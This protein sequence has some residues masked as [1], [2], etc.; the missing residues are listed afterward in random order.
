MS[1]N[2]KTLYSK[3]FD[4]L[5]KTRSIESAMQLCEWDQ[6]TYMPKE[7]IFF[8]SLTL[9][10][11]SEI[12]HKLKTSPAYKK[13]LGSLIDLKTGEIIHSDLSAKDIQN[14]KVLK[15]DFDKQSKLP[16]KFVK[17]FT[18]LSSESSFM[19]QK[20]KEHSDF[21]SFAPYLKNIVKSNQKK[22]AFLGFKHHPY[23]ALID[24]YE[25]GMTT[26]VLDHLFI[27]LKFELIELLRKIKIKNKK[28][29][30]IET[31]SSFHHQM[32]LGRNLLEAIGLKPEFSRL[33]TTTHPF[34]S[35]IG[36]FDIR[37]TTRVIDDD[38]ISNIYSCLH[39]GGHGLYGKGVS[40]FSLGLPEGQSA[41]LGLDE[42]Q[43]RLY[44]T[45]LGKSYGFIEAML[46]FIKEHLKM[47]NLSL[48]TL[49]ENIN[50]VEPHF[51][52]IESDEISYCLHIILRYEIEKALIEG[53]LKVEDVPKIWN[54][55][56]EEYLGIIP[57]HDSQGCLQ[58]IHWSMGAIGYFPTYAL[59]NIY[60]ASLF[61]VFK[62]SHPQFDEELKRFDL[63]ALQ[64]FLQKNLYDH[65]RLLKPL[66]LMK[67]ITPE[68][69]NPEVYLDYLK[70]KYSILYGLD[71]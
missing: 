1:N 5:E 43:S 66:E 4:H 31:Y 65:G 12:H 21:K 16:L 71:S 49:Y 28:F 22:A 59:G 41:S 29:Q 20:A 61:E 6:E 8:R 60:A 63:S 48:E 9:S 67:K 58:D 32:H 53:S 40:K 30:K 57:A 50:K 33:D 35:S 36:P 46:P 23:D 3:L 64:T 17:A 51:I 45:R 56:M 15:E 42:S 47:P 18:K 19:W 7:G 10:N 34:C 62:K 68:G 37:L 55:K 39:E 54:E 52:R 27:K 44:E 2:G 69:L 13:L 38:F 14:L 70:D 26:E 25:P 24:L 11:L